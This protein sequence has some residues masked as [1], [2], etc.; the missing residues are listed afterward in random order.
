MVRILGESDSVLAALLELSRQLA[1][2]AQE[3]H[4]D[5]VVYFALKLLF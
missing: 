4:P 2:F 5:R 3:A 1:K